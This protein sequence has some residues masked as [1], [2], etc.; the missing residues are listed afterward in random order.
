MKKLT[1]KELAVLLTATP[2]I[3]GLGVVGLIVA[4]LRIGLGL[5][6]RYAVPLLGKQVKKLEAVLLARE[7][8]KQRLEAARARRK[9]KREARK[10]NIEASNVLTFRASDFRASEK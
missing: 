5:L 3:L 2:I 6:T 7:Q 9:I 4:P 1:K 10:V 8:R